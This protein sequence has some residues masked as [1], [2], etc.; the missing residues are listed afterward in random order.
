MSTGVVAIVVGLVGL[1]VV[2]TIQ[3]VRRELDPALR[4]RQL[5]LCWLLPVVGPLLALAAHR[6]TVSERDPELD[7]QRSIKESP[8]D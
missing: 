4:T 6:K 2:G 3:I 8:Y 1:A 7:Y 5:L